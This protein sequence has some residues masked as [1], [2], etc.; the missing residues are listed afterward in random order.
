MC[1]YRHQIRNTMIEAKKKVIITNLLIYQHVCDSFCKYCYHHREKGKDPCYTYRYE[2]DLYNRIN[3]I[4]EFS[5]DHYESPIIKICGGEIFLMENLREF[6]EQLLEIYP[7]VLIQ[8]NG[9]HFN[10][11]NLKWIIDSKRILLQISLDGHKTD[12]NRYRFDDEELM[13]SMLNFIRIFRENNIYLE[14]TSVLNNLNT[15]RYEEF[16]QFLNDVPSSI[17]QNTLKVTPILIIDD[18][19]KYRPSSEDIKGIERI[20]DN[21]D[22]YKNILPPKVYMNYLYQLLQGKKLS[23]QCYNPLISVNY[24]DDGKMKGC[25]N[26]LPEDQLNIGN[27]LTDDSVEI[28]KKFGKTKFQKILL[29]TKQWV[30]ICKG[31]FNF[32]SIYNLYMN[33]TITL[34]ELCENNYMFG[35][36]EVRKSLYDI[37]ISLPKIQ[38]IR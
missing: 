19:R 37:K 10:D 7:Y 20:I 16:L 23:Y 4:L 36:P 21:Y 12:M 5:N 9:R 31:C 1:F 34:D 24:I 13:K 2:G 17:L 35:L 33:D 15:A 26:I 28:V 32:C 6:V 18:E 22:T 3:K 38:M 25:T 14:I 27:V 30:P 11:D 8:T 29:E